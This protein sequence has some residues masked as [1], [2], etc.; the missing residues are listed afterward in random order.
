MS[1]TQAKR[2]LKFREDQGFTSVEELDDV[3]DFPRA[4]LNAI[5]ERIV[6]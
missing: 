4:L 5:K 3:P 6:P 1:V 2:V